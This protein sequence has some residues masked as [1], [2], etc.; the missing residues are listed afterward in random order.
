[1]LNDDDKMYHR[2]ELYDQMFNDED[3]TCGCFELCDQLLS[4]KS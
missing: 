3:K 2:F 4:I 1:M